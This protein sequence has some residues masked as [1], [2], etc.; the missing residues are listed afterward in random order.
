MPTRTSVGW[1]LARA[2]TLAFVTTAMSLAGDEGDAY[3]PLVIGSVAVTM[4]GL[5]LCRRRDR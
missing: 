1:F 3:W 4:F 2:G 5:S